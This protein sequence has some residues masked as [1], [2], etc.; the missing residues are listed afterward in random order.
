ME[1]KYLFMSLGHPGSGKTY[2]TTR[3]AEKIGAVR[4]NADALRM[5]MFGSHDAAR[6]FNKETSKLSQVI[7]EAIDYATV[8][9]LKSGN[10][11]I[12]DIQQNERIIRDKTSKLGTDNGAVPIIIWVK[13]PVDIALQRGQDREHTP[14]QQKHDY[15]TMKASIEKHM[16]LIEPPTADEKVIILDGTIPFEDQYRSFIDQLAKL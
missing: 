6:K 11:V 15:E 16:S 5:H 8:Q 7:F 4:L 9:I 10:S 13:T 1:T 12:Y 14:D 2:F 3:L